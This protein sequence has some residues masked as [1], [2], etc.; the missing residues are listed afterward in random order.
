MID[1]RIYDYSKYR[2][3]IVAD[4]DSC[5]WPIYSALNDHNYDE[6]FMINI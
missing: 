5:L 1:K 2:V 3:D 6:E 4:I